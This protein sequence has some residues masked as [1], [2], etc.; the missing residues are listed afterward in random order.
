MTLK[1]V[2]TAVDLFDKENRI[3]TIIKGKYGLKTKSDAINFIIKKFA[4]EHLEEVILP[5]LEDQKA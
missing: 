5:E 1:M 4:E 2:S 3:I